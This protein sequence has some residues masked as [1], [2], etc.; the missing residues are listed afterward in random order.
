M[1]VRFAFCLLSSAIAFVACGGRLV[2]TDDDGGGSAAGG[3]ANQAGVPGSGA[4]HHGGRSGAGGNV[5]AGGNVG[6]AAS[7]S[8]GSFSGATSVGGGCACPDIDC[9]PGDVRVPNADGCCFHCESPC[10][11]VGCP[12]IA[13]GSGSHLELVPGQCCPTCVTDSCEVQHMRYFALQRELFDK[14][15]TLGCMTDADCT[16]Y[17]E[18]NQCAVRCGVVVPVAAIKNLDSNLQSFAQ[19]NCTPDCTLPVTPCPVPRPPSCVGGFCR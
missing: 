12:A 6:A 1:R 17:Y 10:K 19:A 14:Y 13:C 4:S 2:Q 3:S 15:S 5:A 7:P 16:T 9:A 18:K 8:G 11:N